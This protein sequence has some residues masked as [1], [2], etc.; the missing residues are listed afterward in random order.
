VK[1]RIWIG[2]IVLATGLYFLLMHGASR[3]T[4]PTKSEP[5]PVTAETLLAARPE[6]EARISKERQEEFETH[7]AY[8]LSRLRQDD[9]IVK[10]KCLTSIDSLSHADRLHAELQKRGFTCSPLEGNG[11][12]VIQFFICTW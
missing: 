11:S 6:A 1:K 2:G 5:I 8:A 10:R 4:N 3:N 12:R 7:L 9:C